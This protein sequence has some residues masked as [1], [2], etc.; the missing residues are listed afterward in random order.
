[1]GGW[2]GRVRACAHVCVREGV[3]GEGGGGRF[4]KFS[5]EI[6]VGL[7]YDLHDMVYL[8]KVDLNY[9]CLVS[10]PLEWKVF[11]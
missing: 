10:L 5:V 11:I 1:M 2:G 7:P 3:G 4:L 6:D 9:R 8:V